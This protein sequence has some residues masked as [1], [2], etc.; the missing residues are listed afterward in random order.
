MDTLQ[1][2]SLWIL[3][4]S[5][6]HPRAATRSWEDYRQNVV[7]AIFRYPSSFAS[8]FLTPFWPASYLTNFY[9][10]RYPAICIFS[11]CVS[12]VRALFGGFLIMAISIFSLPVQSTAERALQKKETARSHYSSFHVSMLTGRYVLSL[13]KFPPRRPLDFWSYAIRQ[14]L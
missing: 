12:I 6:R 9:C 1:Q 11:L 8:L 14:Y 10:T 7:H 4:L 13:Q 2:A 3:G 5:R